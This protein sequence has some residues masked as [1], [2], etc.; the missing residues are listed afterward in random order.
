MTYTLHM[1]LIMSGTQSGDV[2]TLAHGGVV[3]V[4]KGEGGTVSWGSHH[5][6]VAIVIPD[7]S[8]AGE[9][10]QELLRELSGQFSGED[11]AIQ[12]WW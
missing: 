6:T 5:F 8:M 11:G 2:L 9:R 12:K 7:G 3:T 4:A 1:P 10:E